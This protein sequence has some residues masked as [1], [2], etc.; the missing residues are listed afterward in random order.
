MIHLLP[1]LRRSRAHIPHLILLWLHIGEPSLLMELL[2]P[3]ALVLENLLRSVTIKLRLVRH[4][5]NLKRLTMDIPTSSV[6]L[7]RLLERTTF[8][9][10]FEMRRQIGRL[11]P[12]LLQLNLLLQKLRNLRIL[13]HQFLELINRHMPTRSRNIIMISLFFYFLNWG[14]LFLWGARICN[15]GL[16]SRSFT[17]VH[18]LLNSFLLVRAALKVRVSRGSAF[19]HVLVGHHF[20]VLGS[21]LHWKSVVYVRGLR[22]LIWNFVRRDFWI[23]ASVDAVLAAL[24]LLHDFK[25]LQLVGQLSSLFLLI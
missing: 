4:I 15:H 18:F 8:G 19:W 23:H 1:S 17:W 21:L 7:W 14:L 9:W 12:S 22:T 20:Q 6:I 25:L 10:Y 11:L 2:R 5:R 3:L 13:H 24:D 16:S